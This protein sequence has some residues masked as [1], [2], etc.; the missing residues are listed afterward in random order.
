MLKKI[1]KLLSIATLL[2]SNYSFATSPLLCPTSTY[3]K[4]ITFTHAVKNVTLDAVWY[5][6]S[7][8]FKWR[9]KTWNVLFAVYLPNAKT[10]A[11]ALSQ[12]QQIFAADAVPNIPKHYAYSVQWNNVYCNYTPRYAS[13]IL[14]AVNEL[15]NEEI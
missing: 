7:N 3:I 10:S 6:R 2:I 1:F 4:N 15:P 13:Y 5:L 8:T 12:G 11:E 14:K 9:E